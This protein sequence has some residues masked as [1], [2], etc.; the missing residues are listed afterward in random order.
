MYSIAGESQSGNIYK[1]LMVGVW[2]KGVMLESKGIEFR[3]YIPRNSQ[4]IVFKINS[5][6]C[7]KTKTKG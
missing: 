1:I 6:L 2:D 5:N 4:I 7:P 3:Q